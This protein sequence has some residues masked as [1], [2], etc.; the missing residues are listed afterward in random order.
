MVL[1]W[2]GYA[3]QLAYHNAEIFYYVFARI[4][5]PIEFNYIGIVERMD[6]T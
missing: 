6:K 5:L 1:T 2:F 3:N 4:L